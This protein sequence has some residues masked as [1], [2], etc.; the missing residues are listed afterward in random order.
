MISRS[1]RRHW[2]GE[3]SSYNPKV[4]TLCTSVAAE[5]NG[6]SEWQMQ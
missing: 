6:V 3:T 1:R 2:R 4:W 5:E